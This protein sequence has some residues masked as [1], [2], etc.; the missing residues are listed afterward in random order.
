MYKITQWQVYTVLYHATH[1]SKLCHSFALKPKN[2]RHYTLTVAW[3]N[4]KRACM[5]QYHVFFSV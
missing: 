5:V 1:G 3:D 2:S 4:T